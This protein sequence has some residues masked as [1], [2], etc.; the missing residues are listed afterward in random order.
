MLKTGRV[1]LANPNE[2]LAI[3][4]VTTPKQGDKYRPCGA[5]NDLNAKT[6]P[7]S[8]ELPLIRDVLREF[9]P[10]ALRFFVVD[11][12]KGF[13]AVAATPEASK[14]TALWSVTQPGQVIVPAVMMFGPTNAP[15][16]FDAVM[17]NAMAGL[18]LKRIV[19]ELGQT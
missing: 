4:N 10:D 2:V 1:R 6:K 14:L 5:Y 18:G 12:S 16:Y 11:I 3:S 15:F 17:A 9:K 7:Q 8:R 13:Y 19:D